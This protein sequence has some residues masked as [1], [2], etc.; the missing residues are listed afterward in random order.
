[1]GTWLISFAIFLSTFAFR[2]LLRLLRLH[3]LRRTAH[4]VPAHYM[5]DLGLERSAAPT[6]FSCG[7][8][9]CGSPGAN[10]PAAEAGALA[11]RR[12]G[13]AV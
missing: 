10:S 11:D 12:P 8:R 4:Q 2:P 9:R 3:N 5:R 7:Q 13:A 1:L 6:G